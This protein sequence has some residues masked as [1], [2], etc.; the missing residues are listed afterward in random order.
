[1]D[2][3]T[4]W[5]SIGGDLVD[6]SGVSDEVWDTALETALDPTTVLSE[7]LIPDELTDDIVDIAFAAAPADPVD[8]IE[9]DEML[10]ASADDSGFD[11]DA[12][13]DDDGFVDL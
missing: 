12:D 1:M 11:S 9:V 10:L 5:T 2:D 4:W 7:D 3:L 8:V 6:A 13:G